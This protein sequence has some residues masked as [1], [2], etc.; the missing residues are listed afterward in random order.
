MSF[1]PPF[2]PRVGN[3]LEILGAILYIRQLVTEGDVL[4]SPT[5]IVDLPISILVLLIILVYILRL[6]C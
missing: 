5:M 1:T 3:S 2:K 6:C 4:K